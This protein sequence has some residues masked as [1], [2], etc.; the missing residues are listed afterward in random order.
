MDQHKRIAFVLTFLLIWICVASCHN[1]AKV[2]VSEKVDNPNRMDEVVAQTIQQ[3]LD[4]A[5]DNNEALDDT[6]RL[7]LT[8]MLKEFYR[9][10]DYK[11]TWSQ[12]EKWKPLAD[13]LFQYIQKAEM[14][15][16]FPKDYYI[17]PITA[18]KKL[19]DR[20]SASRTDAA[21]WARAD[22]LM[23]DACLLLM[24]DLKY[25]RLQ[26]DSVLFK[27]DDQVK[28]SLFQALDELS[29]ANSFS[30]VMKQLQPN[31]RAYWELKKGIPRFLDS[32]D[33]RQYTYL[34]YP[35][36][37]NDVKDST[38]FVQSLE[39]RLK[40]GKWIDNKFAITDTGSLRTAIK[41]YQQV[42][43]IKADG[44]LS[45][46]LV[47]MLNNTDRE[48]FNRIAITLDRFKQLP[49]SMP[50][51]YIWVNLPGY[52]LQVWDNDSLALE[53]KV[54]CGKPET[55]T[56]I[57]TSQ[58][59]NM[60]IYPTWT[61]PTSIIAKQYL[62]K[63]KNNPNYLARLGLKLTN[64]K[65][66]AVNA[67]SINWSKY[68]KGIPY[69]VMQN[70]GDDNALGVMKFNFSNDFDVYLHDT[71]QR[72]LFKNASRALSHGC[73]RVQQWEELA[74]YLVH[75]DSMHL[76]EGDSLRYNAD[77]IR[78]WLSQK[79]KKQ[80]NV[81][82]GLALFIRYFSCEGKDGKIKFYDDVYGEDRQLRERYFAL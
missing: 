69:R 23:S 34:R 32:M 79:Q 61:V 50:A 1:K 19:L 62:P 6:T 68:N 42:K 8:L 20:D 39:K 64:W 76:K 30:S 15:G 31:H 29:K 45:T 28:S 2:P 12:M 63:L 74:F 51:Q 37:A 10:H 38:G 60:V 16:L 46:A 13:S 35:F 27:K 48:K 66:E 3:A 57:I 11:P 56:P 36:K 73:V 17:R 55:R 70:S 81:K 71:N 59:T 5:L 33:K 25:G 82:S 65:G 21:I 7:E 67:S 77:S 53:S 40:E 9:K 75:N 22:V 72:Y 41:K 52:Y 47:K 26:A 58:I 44:K 14:H 43:G 4:A 80:I 49:D 18:V 24:K 78:N 54:I